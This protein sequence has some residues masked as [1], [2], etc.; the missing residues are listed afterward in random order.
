MVSVQNQ[1]NCTPVLCISVFHILNIEDALTLLFNFLVESRN[2][3]I[4]WGKKHISDM[5]IGCT[6]LDITKQQ[7]SLCV[8][9]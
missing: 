2:M 8:S 4:E 9:L 7:I 5:L 3:D 1:N 6:N